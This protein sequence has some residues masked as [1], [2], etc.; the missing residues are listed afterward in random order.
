MA[1]P[2]WQDWKVSEDNVLQMLE[3]NENDMVAGCYFDVTISAP[4][5]QN[6]C[7]IPTSFE[8]Y[9][10][11]QEDMK[12]IYDY[13]YVADGTEGSTLTIPAIA[14]KKIVFVARDGAILYPVSNLPDN[15]QYVFDGTTIQ[16][17]LAVQ[18]AGER[19]L[20]LYRSI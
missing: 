2:G 8:D 7:Q 9:G 12:L 5:T 18:K 17:G 11:I 6:I 15:T 4:F 1:F 14:G 13:I 19:F 3:E 16:L 10:S 20:I